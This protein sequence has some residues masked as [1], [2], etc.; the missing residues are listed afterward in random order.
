MLP[1]TR[2]NLSQR[3]Q[4][5]LARRQIKVDSAPDPK[6]TAKRSWKTFSG[7]A[8]VEVMS[9]LQNMA[10]GLDRCMYCEDSMGTD[11]DHFR[12]KHHYPE[13]AF[14]WSNYYLA[15][16]HCNSNQKRGEF[17][18]LPGGIPGLIDPCVQDPFN[19]F[20]FSPSTGRY[21]ERDELGRNTIR[22][23]G[24]NRQVCVDGRRNAWV[25]L[26]ALVVLYRQAPEKRDQILHTIREYP[27]QGV[28]RHMAQLMQS[29]KRDLLLP[30]GVV[31]AVSRHPELSE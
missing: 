22:V 9:S 28:R 18:L 21:V 3:T 12:P 14:V 26:E 16:S 17:P 24:L 10:S 23:F 19:H 25:A 5:V 13:A 7:N 30:A 4:T 15:C 8:R 6:D 2:G 27:F 1:L 11:I 31:I 20:D 29:P